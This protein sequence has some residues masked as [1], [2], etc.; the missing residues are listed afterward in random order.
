M[1]VRVSGW[2]LERGQREALL[3]RFPAAYEI[4]VCDHVTLKFGGRPGFEPADTSA[5]IIGFANDRRGV[6]AAIV[7]IA[8]LSARPDGGVYHITWSLAPGRR[9]V[10]SNDV[11]AEHGWA[12]LPIGVPVELKAA[13]WP[14]G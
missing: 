12:P 9:A 10:E 13:S 6:Q 2:K 5:E 1:G 14:P 3:Q 8:G 11:I 4:V 7:E